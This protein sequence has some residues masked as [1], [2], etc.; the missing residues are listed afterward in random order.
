MTHL[1]ASPQR[2]AV[3]AYASLDYRLSPHAAFPQDPATTPAAR[4]RDARHPDHL[5]DVRA[6]L[7]ALQ[8]RYGFGD[9][10]VL[11][12]HSAGATLAFQVLMGDAA[13][14]AGSTTALP[15][16]GPEPV[17]PAAVVGLEGIYD[18][19][20]LVRRFGPAYAEFVTAAFGPPGDDDTNESSSSVWAAASPARFAGGYGTRWPAGRLAVLGWSPDDELIDEPE[21]DALAAVL[22]RDGV[23]LRVFKDLE[24]RHN[25]LYEDGRHFARLICEALKQLA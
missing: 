3:A 10:Y 18:L 11:V 22:A 2:F 15:P 12:G 8:A 7:V 21:V 9:R 5:V 24:G 23:P 19:P 20:G 14:A 17:L 25:A 13:V 6:A 1:L 4:R 16:L